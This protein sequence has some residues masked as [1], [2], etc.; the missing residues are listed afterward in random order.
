M[1][2]TGPDPAEI[3]TLGGD[4]FPA[5]DRVLAV[6]WRADAERNGVPQALVATTLAFAKTSQAAAWMLVPYIGWVSFAMTLNL[7]IW[8]RNA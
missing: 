8:R 3:R 4:A 5:L 1:P 7:E 6:A 2:T